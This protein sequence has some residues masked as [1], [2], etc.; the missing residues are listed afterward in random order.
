MRPWQTTPWLFAFGLLAGAC[1]ADSE[2]ANPTEERCLA[3]AQCMVDDCSDELAELEDCI[4]AGG[5]ASLCNQTAVGQCAE[6]CH[7]AEASREERD[8]SFAL[9][10]CEAGDDDDCSEQ[11]DA[12]A[13]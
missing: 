12:C 4:E 10:L 11:A 2:E 8:A 7:D 1:P 13:L 9:F 6:P 5:D 3:A